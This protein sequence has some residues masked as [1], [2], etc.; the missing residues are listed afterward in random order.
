MHCRTTS[1]SRHPVTS[2]GIDLSS[3]HPVEHGHRKSRAINTVRRAGGIGKAVTP[4]F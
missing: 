4:E 2:L 1:K 3:G